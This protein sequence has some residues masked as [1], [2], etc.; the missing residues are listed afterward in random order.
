M[1]NEHDNRE[2]FYKMQDEIQKLHKSLDFI[3]NHIRFNQ[4]YIDSLLRKDEVKADF[5]R[6][7]IVR[8]MLRLIISGYDE[9]TAIDQVKS[10]YKSLSPRLID[11]IWDNAKSHRGAL[12]LY[13]RAYTAK[14]M[15]LAGFTLAEIAQTLN[16]SVTSIQKLLKQDCYT[17]NI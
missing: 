9:L 15:R 2:N 8:Y 17:V 11:W 7:R 3:S 6:F 5:H 12:D 13:A 1:Y 10:L 4:D 16:L 14:K